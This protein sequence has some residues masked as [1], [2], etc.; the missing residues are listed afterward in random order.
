MR[1]IFLLVFITNFLLSR[2]LFIP[3]PTD[4]EY[5]KNIVKLGKELFNDPMLSKNGDISCMSCHFQYGADP[6]RFSIGTDGKLGNMNSPSLF[7]AKFNI[8]LFW[9]GRTL[10]LEEQMLDGPIFAEHEMASSKELIEERLRKSKKYRKMFKKAFGIEPTFEKAV[11]SIAEFEKT[12]I[13]PNSKFDK[14][15]RKEVKL[16]EQENRGFKLFQS[17]GCVSCHNGINIGGNSYQELGAVIEYN[18]GEQGWIDRYTHTKNSYDKNV[19]RVASLRNIEKTAPY[20]H[21]GSIKTL[22]KAIQTMGYNN[23]GVVLSTE[24]IEDLESFLKT[25]TGELPITLQ[26]EL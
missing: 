17:Y 4:I 10:T 3:L 9:N 12:L 11:K 22:K 1:I 2:D 14:F 5:D 6:K 13:T 18:S 8:G 16:N 21:H 19:F 23:I 24:E 15:L 20:F 7:N 25:L 26:E